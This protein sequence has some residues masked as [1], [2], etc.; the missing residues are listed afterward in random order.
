MIIRLTQKKIISYP[1]TRAVVG[2]YNFKS[3][4]SSGH[5][6]VEK[7]HSQEENQVSRTSSS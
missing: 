5:P 6:R 7:G 3:S 1:V 2:K 4:V